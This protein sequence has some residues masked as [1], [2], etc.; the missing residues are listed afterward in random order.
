VKKKT[1]GPARKRMRKGSSGQLL[2]ERR[3]LPEEEMR[4][5]ERKILKNASMKREVTKKACVD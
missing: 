2:R 5:T 1:K 3:K 4:G